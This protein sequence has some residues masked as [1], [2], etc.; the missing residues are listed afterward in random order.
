MLV[1]SGSR[2][3]Q[4]ANTTAAIT[5]IRNTYFIGIS[6]PTRD[7][8]GFPNRIH[9]ARAQ[10][11]CQVPRRVYS[12][13]AAGGAGCK[14]ESREIVATII[15]ER[16]CMVATSLLSKA[17]GVDD[18]TSKTPR[19]RRKWRRGATRMERTPILRQLAESTRELESASLH[20]NT[21]PG[22]THSAESPGAG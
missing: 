13:E 21:S 22:R 10:T 9:R 20:S 3:V 5:A 12:P 6:L 16:N 19:V 17:W 15:P 11:D 14:L 8:L 1:T 7:T 18:S 4:A 2:I